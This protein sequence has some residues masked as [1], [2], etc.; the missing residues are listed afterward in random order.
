MS[1]L[2]PSSSPPRR[3]IV[4]PV[5]PP[6]ATFKPRPQSGIRR[7]WTGFHTHLGNVAA[8][9]VCALLLLL[10]LAMKLDLFEVLLRAIGAE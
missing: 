10:F 2:P 4:P 7:A 5:V 6:P 9:L 8:A 1:V 3:P